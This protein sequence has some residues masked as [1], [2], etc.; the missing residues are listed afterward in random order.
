MYPSTEEGVDCSLYV[1]AAAF[2]ELGQNHVCWCAPYHLSQLRKW[3]RCRIGSSRGALS[4]CTTEIAGNSRLY[5]SF[6]VFEEPACYTEHKGLSAPAQRET[7]KFRACP[8]DIL[9]FDG[10]GDSGVQELRCLEFCIRFK[11]RVDLGL[12]NQA[13][14]AMQQLDGTALRAWA[15]QKGSEQDQAE[16]I[17]KRITRI[18]GYS[19]LKH[20]QQNVDV[21]SRRH[22]QP[23]LIQQTQGLWP[24]LCIDWAPSQA[25]L[26]LKAMTKQDWK[27]S[28][29]SR[30]VQNSTERQHA[31][32]HNSW[33]ILD[34]RQKQLSNI[35]RYLFLQLL[36]LVS[37]GVSSTESGPDRTKGSQS[38]A[39]VSTAMSGTGVS[40]ST[41]CQACG[42]LTYDQEWQTAFGVFLCPHC[43]SRE[44]LI[45]KVSIC[46]LGRNCLASSLLPTDLQPT[47]R[48]P[49]QTANLW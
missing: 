19:S 25:S 9:G 24:C 26:F 10:E 37:A 4:A 7:Q 27:P 20:V 28:E 12:D 23:S 16:I 11:H 32:C 17:S 45:A 22:L 47:Y 35:T 36:S 8:R 21:F 15:G 31:V 46:N 38:R 42:S 43:K 40:S 2:Q 49:H 44:S 34:A 41:G 39:S 30:G 1:A 33:M 29:A 5:R 3:W 14:A 48:L 13:K 6:C 18:R